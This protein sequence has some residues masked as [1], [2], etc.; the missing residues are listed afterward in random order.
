MKKI[1]ILLLMVVILFGFDFKKEYSQNNFTKICK[2]GYYHINEIKNNEDILSLVGF[3]CVKRDYFIYLPTIINYLKKTKKA[4]DNSIYFSLLFIEK[5]LLISYVIDGMDLSYYRFPLIK[6]PLSIV[7]THIINKDFT[8]Q[9]QKI[10]IKDNNKIYKVYKDEQNRVFIDIYENN[11][12]K[13]S[14]WYR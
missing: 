11:E 14:H 4:R 6:H 2:Y 3:A 12:L 5:K 13:E 8:K 10:I 7:I 9:D 1:S